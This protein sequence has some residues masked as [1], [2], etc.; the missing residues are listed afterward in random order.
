MC[1][2]LTKTLHPLVNPSEFVCGTLLWI[3]FGISP[4]IYPI[5]S[6]RFAWCSFFEFLLGVLP[7]PYCNFQNIRTILFRGLRIFQDSWIPTDFC[8]C[9]HGNVD[10]FA[11]FL[12]WSIPRSEFLLRYIAG[13]YT[14]FLIMFL[15]VNIALENFLH[16]FRCSSWDLLKR[17][18]RDF[19]QSCCR[20]C[21]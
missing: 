9:F 11:V 4:R 17:S 1:D 18:S 6:C 10:I 13:I 5:F 16:S 20:S 21:L 3:P 12:S 19:Y 14:E 7:D 2:K 8:W 15:P